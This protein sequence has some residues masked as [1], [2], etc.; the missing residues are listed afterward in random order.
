M[1]KLKDTSSLIKLFYKSDTVWHITVEGYDP[2]PFRK[3]AY[4]AMMP[5]AQGLDLYSQQVL[6]DAEHGV[7]YYRD[8]SIRIPFRGGI[9]ADR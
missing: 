8:G 1:Y 6:L 9:G 7:D 3:G 4:I 5:L 2:G